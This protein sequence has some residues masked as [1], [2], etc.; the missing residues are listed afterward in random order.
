MITPRSPARAPSGTIKRFSVSRAGAHPGPI[1]TNVE[2]PE[3]VFATALA[4]GTLVA[5]D[6]RTATALIAEVLR[7]PP[8][9]AR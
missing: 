5:K 7:D 9:V 3:A 1:G 4:E 8:R 6:L 2:D